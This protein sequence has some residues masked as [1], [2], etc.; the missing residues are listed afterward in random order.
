MRRAD[1]TALGSLMSASHRSLRDLHEVSTPTMDAVASAARAVPGCAGA[2][3]VGAGFGGTV[4]ALVDRSAADPCR[5]A[6]ADACAGGETFELRSSPGVAV[7]A[8][9]VVRG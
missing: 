4:V 1:L 5:H 3:L 8:P 2:R 6:M 9:D 7:L